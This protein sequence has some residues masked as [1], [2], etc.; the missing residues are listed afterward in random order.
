MKEVIL[1]M[2]TQYNEELRSVLDS[3]R[4]EM[5]K[6][7]E[8]KNKQGQAGKKSL[9]KE[10]AKIFS[11]SKNGETMLVQKTKHCL[12]EKLF[13]AASDGEGKD[14]RRKFEISLPK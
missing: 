4:L 13:V 6:K 10:H 7:I 11:Q 8:Q 5:S 1:Y 14:H 9:H 3:F 2:K 12:A